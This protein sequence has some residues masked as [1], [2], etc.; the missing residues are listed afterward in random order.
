MSEDDYEVGE[1]GGSYTETTTESWGER[2]MGSIKS[3]GT[4]ALLFI[5]SFPVLWMNEGCAVKIAR[6]LSEGAG[7]VVAVDSSKFES[8]N[9]GKLVHM[10]GKAETSEMLKDVTFGISKSAIKLVRSVE[11]YQWV[12]EKSS[13]SEKQL[14][15]KKKTVT[16]YTYKKEWSST[17]KDSKS[18]RVKKDTKTGVYHTNP[19]SM[20]YTGET[21]AAKEVKLGAYVLS[22]DLISKIGGSKKITLTEAELKN[23]PFSIKGRAKIHQGAIYIGS[24]PANPQVGDTKISF[25]YVEPKEVSIVAQQKGKSFEAY[26]TKTGTSILMLSEGKKAAKDM[27]Q[28]AQE[29]NAMRTWIMRLVGFLMM[30]FGLKM[31]FDP[32]VT[33]ADVVPFIGSF[34]DIG[35]GL[36]AGLFAFGLSFLTIAIAWIFY[37]PL[38]GIGLLILAGAAIGGAYYLKEQKAKEKQAAPA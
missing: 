31:V 35:I 9:E 32:L 19:A 18:F 5:V 22:P 4:G 14:G 6:G 12:E 2:L 11:M 23:L 17:L 1:E 37:R 24:D 20:P 38:L 10:S 28:A 13:K 8:A 36:F 25:E 30:F 7:N 26:K 15:G 29:G 21:Y 16:T 27:F 3:V 33:L 34:L